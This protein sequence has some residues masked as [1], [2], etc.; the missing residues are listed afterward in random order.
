MTI[1]KEFWALM[2]VWNDQIKAML[3]SAIRIFSP[4][5]FSK[6]QSTA[7]PLENEKLNV[8]V[9]KQK[10]PSHYS[11]P[12]LIGL[13]IGPF[14][15]IVI[16]ICVSPA[17]M[18]NEAI[19]V[20]ASI[21]WVATWWV[22]EAVPIPIT[23]LLPLLL[24]P[25]TGV[26]ETGEVS[27]SYGDS[28]IFLFA[29]SF[30]I[31]LSMEKWNL[32]RRVALSIISFVGT[33]PSTIIL[34]FMIA[35][36]F[37]SMWISNTATTLMMVPISLAVTKH[38]SDSLKN[39]TSIDT[40]P[41]KF[42]FGTAL[43]LGTA[44]SATI[45]GFGSLIGAPANI[46]LAGTVSR[47]YGV[48]IT[49]ARWLLFGVPMVVI[50]IPL[51]WLY[52]TKVAFPLKVKEIPGGR[53]I[54]KKDLQGLGKMSY[55]E[56]VVLTVFIL[57]AVAWI[58]RSF[59]LNK[60]VPGLD[61][62]LIALL[63][64]VILFLIPAKNKEGNIMDWNTALKLPWGILWL[65]GG[66][67]A[68]AAGIMNSGLD[69]WIGGQLTNFEHVPLFFTIA[70][71]VTLITTLTE[72]TSNTATAT[73]VYPI[74]AVAAASLGTDPIVLMVAANMGA[75]FAYMFPVA[76]P[77]NAIVFGTG[78]V[79]MADMAKTGVWLNLFSITFTVIVVYYYVPIIFGH[80]M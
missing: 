78:Y 66:G 37:L 33:N 41:G 20:L 5:T 12:Q 4:A 18:P 42:P 21:A 55:E 53:E 51:V 32:H 39:N 30:M 14:L 47:L 36:G 13:F 64:G 35:T 65:F 15:F 75:T 68:L 40:A 23:S 46:I 22:T 43:M 49:F 11:K 28:L 38:V 34:G 8:E 71:I 44:Y 10:R 27:A 48:E 24:F 73:M 74:V 72:F 52:L 77:P 63:A 70:L 69:Q 56:K 67:L 2:W 62:T 79:R 25:M 45:G 61:D 58:T 76:A 26:M 3:T 60:F 31:A 29:G 7:E 6:M 59:F 54:I 9:E 57:T 16:K 50:I 1:V 17:E 19:T 80:L